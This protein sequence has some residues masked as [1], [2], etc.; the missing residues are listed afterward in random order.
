VAPVHNALEHALAKVFLGWSTW[1][2]TAQAFP[3]GLSYS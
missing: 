1:R 3:P 2:Q